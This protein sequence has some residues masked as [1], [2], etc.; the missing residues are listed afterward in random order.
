MLKLR[1]LAPHAYGGL[2]TYWQ[3]GDTLS[4]CGGRRINRCATRRTPWGTDWINLDGAMKNAWRPG[5]DSGR[6]TWAEL[7]LGGEHQ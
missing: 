6:P 5:R 7:H 2:I 1:N 4:R 3:P